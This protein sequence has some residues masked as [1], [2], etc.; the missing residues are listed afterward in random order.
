M[1]T[2]PKRVRRRISDSQGTS[3][4]KFYV[5]YYPF[6][7][8]AAIYS[9]ANLEEAEL[10]AQE[11]MVKAWRAFERFDH[12]YPKAWLRRILGRVVIDRYHRLK[13]QREV[14]SDK[15]FDDV[16]RTEQA[17]VGDLNV[18]ADYLLLEQYLK[19]EA[20]GE[21]ASEALETWS[22][23]HLSAEL[24]SALEKISPHH[25]I[26][27]IARELLELSYQEIHVMLD[28][29]QGTVMSRLHRARHALQS[30]LKADSSQDHDSSH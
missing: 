23:R 14:F 6:V 9:C 29:P 18:E 16:E 1:P 25:R 5:A 7:K 4:R 22:Q 15:D 24:K 8:Q 19:D 2:S 12:Q 3:F 27:L 30:E 21:S 20:R 17:V 11:T 13:R 10:V 26:V 28:I